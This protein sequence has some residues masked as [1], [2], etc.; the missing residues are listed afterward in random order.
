MKRAGVGRYVIAVIG[1]EKV[2]AF[3]PAPLLPLPSLEI[4]G[5]ARAAID[6][7]LLSLGR[8]DGAA[9][10]LPDAKLLL[11]TFVRKEAVLSSQIEG[12]QSSL[13]DLLT[14][15]SGRVLACQSKTLPRYHDTLL[16]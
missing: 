16:Q 11:Y 10:T 8:L 13:S 12:T 2:R 3:V 15:S 7:A 5:S 9:A 6:Q 14:T 4:T 1:G